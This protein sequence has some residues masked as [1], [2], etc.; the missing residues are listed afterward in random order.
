MNLAFHEE[1]VRLL[2]S[3]RTVAVATVVSRQ[4]SAPRGAGTR[5]VITESGETFFTIG[6]GAFEALVIEDARAAVRTGCGLEKVYRFSE[7]GEGATGMVCGGAA[8]VLIEVVRPPAPLV[9]YGAGHVGRELAVIAA[10]LEFDVTVVDDRQRYLAPE[11]FPPGVKAIRAERDFSAGM[12][13]VPPGAYVAI[14]TRCHR[15]DLMAV[16]HSVGKWAA[17]VGLIGS[18]RKVATVLARAGEMGT[19]PEELAEIRGPIGLAIGA[20]TPQEIAVSIAAEIIAL[21][22]E[23][24]AALR[25]APA[26]PSH[27]TSITARRAARRP[28]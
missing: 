21:R 28:V 12:P 5:M 14:V 15:T 23:G 20:Q 19:P 10:R 2:R 9:I 4:G 24:P 13:S 26:P 18:R 25:H 16:R 8:K 3:G 17:Y 7:S 22:N 6:G 1:M 27:V 11:R